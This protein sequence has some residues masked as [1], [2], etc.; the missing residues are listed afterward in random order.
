M[1]IYP[2]ADGD[3][4]LYDDDGVSYAYEK[5]ASTEVA[6]HWDN[7]AQKLTIGARHG[8]FTNMPKELVF[9]PVL[10]A[11]G[12]G[13]GSLAEYE[14]AKRITYTGEAVVWQR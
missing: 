9:K 4:T 6:L 13:I 3:F 8:Q 1:R 2:G 14:G 12:T 5:G 10:V 11:K 7:A